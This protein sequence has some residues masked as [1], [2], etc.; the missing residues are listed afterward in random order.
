MEGLQKGW[1]SEVSA[2]SPGQAMSIEVEGAPLHH[3]KVNKYTTSYPL[4]LL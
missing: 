2:F 4:I 1:F 3:E